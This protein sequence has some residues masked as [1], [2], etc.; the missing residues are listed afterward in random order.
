MPDSFLVTGAA[1]KL[2]IANTS[3]MFK[4]VAVNNKEGRQG[5]KLEERGANITLINE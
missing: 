3:T 5:T 4:I 2:E 1:T